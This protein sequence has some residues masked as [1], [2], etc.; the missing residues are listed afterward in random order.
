MRPGEEGIIRALEHIAADQ[1]GFGKP[2]SPG[3]DEEFSAVLEEIAD[4]NMIS[5][6]ILIRYMRR[7]IA[8]ICKLLDRID[9]LDP[10]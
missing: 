4:G 10:V 5:Q 6:G 2:A 9:G 7:E 8:N 1:A 3:S